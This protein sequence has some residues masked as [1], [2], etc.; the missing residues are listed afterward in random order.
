MIRLLDVEARRVLARRA[1]R[2]SFLVVFLGLLIGGVVLFSKSHAPDPRQIQAQIAQRRSII[3][4]CV[5]GEG[6]PPDVMPP[7]MTRRQFCEQIAPQ[8]EVDGNRFRLTHYAD[9]AQGLSGLFVVLLTGLGA[10]LIGAEWH[11]GTIT[12]LL[13]WEPRRVRVLGAKLLVIFALG[14]VG[15]LVLEALLLLVVL[16]AALIRGSTAGADGPWISHT[17]AL[18]L[19]GGV[20]A[21]MGA[22]IGAVIASIARNT[23]AA[24]AAF[25]VYVA[26]L[27]PL[28]RAWK[29]HLER[30]L[31]GTNAVAF[32]SGAR[33]VFLYGSHSL[34]TSAL[35][36]SF[37]VVL[38]STIAVALFVRRDVT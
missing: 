14:F 26:V 13:T 18:I 24:I 5:N 21:G 1:V 28:L 17:V 16:P 29:P 23:A 19:R 36:L 8:V 15:F 4:S 34:A 20:L 11:A 35:L 6:P 7:G 27:E 22:T 12:T 38:A 3:E 2:A 9:A 32:V 31:L 10:S 33:D 30:W 25:F 37:Y